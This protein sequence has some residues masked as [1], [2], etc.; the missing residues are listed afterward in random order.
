MTLLSGR[1]IM[2]GS[3]DTSDAAAFLEFL[4]RLPHESSHTM[5]QV[6]LDSSVTPIFRRSRLV[7][8]GMISRNLI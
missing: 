3:L 4:A 8:E 7:G 2:L 6:Y 1:T 5:Q